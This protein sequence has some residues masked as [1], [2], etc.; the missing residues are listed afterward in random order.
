MPDD[1]TVQGPRGGMRP[2]GMRPGGGPGG[3]PGGFPGGFPGG[4]PGGFPGGR[5]GGFPRRFP[6]PRFPRTRFPIFFPIIIPGSPSCFYYDRF[7]RCC[8]RY[9]WCC[10][11]F[12]RCGW[13]WGDEYASA[14]AMSVVD[15]DEGFYGMPG[16]WDLDYDDD[17]DWD[18]D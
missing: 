2:G 16:Y 3:R 17:D 9:G 5:P 14:P 4:R 13:E 12:G 6:R 7:G 15:R 1:L 8:N 18:D 11:R 10:D